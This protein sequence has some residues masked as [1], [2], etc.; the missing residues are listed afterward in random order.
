MPVT[1]PRASAEFY[2]RFAQMRIVHERQEAGG[3]EV[4]WISDRTRPFVVVLL[5][6]KEVTDRIDHL[7]VGC[8]SRDE[9]DRRLA[10]ARTLGL[11][12]DGP[13]DSPPPVG[14]WGTIQ[15]PDGHVL[16]LAFGQEVGLTVEGVR[17]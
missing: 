15:D 9:V 1:D 12:V 3:I 5:P 17:D 2:A 13:H 7:G 10:V 8:A 11:V 4:L 6:V 14:Y 16:E